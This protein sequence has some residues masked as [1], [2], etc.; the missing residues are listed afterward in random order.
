MLYG[1]N[2]SHANG[3]ITST[4]ARLTADDLESHAGQATSIARCS[5]KIKTL[6]S[7]SAVSCSTRASDIRATDLPG[8][9]Q[10]PIAAALGSER[11]IIVFGPKMGE[12]GLSRLVAILW[13]IL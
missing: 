2:G 8:A 9:G 4:V 6:G 13:L 3:S 10:E 11:S 7:D 1:A 5:D 12:I